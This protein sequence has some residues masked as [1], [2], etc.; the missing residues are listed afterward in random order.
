MMLNVNRHTHTGGI[1]RAG[2]RKFGPVPELIVVVSDE[3]D[4][5][6]GFVGIDGEKLLAVVALA[7]DESDKEAA[8]LGA[9]EIFQHADLQ[10]RLHLVASRMLGIFEQAAIASAAAGGGGALD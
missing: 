10:I 1:V 4:L 3:L 7:V 9:Q 5:I 2:H 6:A 8:G